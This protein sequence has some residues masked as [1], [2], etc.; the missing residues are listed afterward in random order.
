MVNKTLNEIVRGN[1]IKHR[2]GKFLLIERLLE[3][4]E[5][6]SIKHYIEEN[7]SS[8]YLEKLRKIY[9]QIRN[10]PKKDMLFFDIETC[11]FS[12]NDPIFAIGMTHLNHHIKSSCIFARDYSEEK[13]I[14]QYFVDILPKYHC[15]FTYNG[16][17]FDITRLDKRMKANGIKH[18]SKKHPSLRK[19]M[20]ESHIDLMNELQTLKGLSLPDFKLKTVEKVLFGMSRENDALSKDLPGI[21]RKYVN[22]EE[23]DEKMASALEHA[24]TDTL[25]L[26]AI[27]AYIS[28]RKLK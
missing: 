25:T 19:A 6:N 5:D 10:I 14:L 2:G 28:N 11:G 4:S 16:I 1:E 22:G 21:Y 24:I 3:E 8:L 27:L 13:T 12:Y 15:F 23:S 26:P 20:H 9:P 17:A 18:T 7:K